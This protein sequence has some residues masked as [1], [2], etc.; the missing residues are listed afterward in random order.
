M[1][2]SGRLGGAISLIIRHSGFRFLPVPFLPVGKEE[3]V[4]RD[5]GRSK[6][7]ANGHRTEKVNGDKEQQTRLMRLTYY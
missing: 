5:L 1:F 7:Q 3:L 4:E 6:N 2:T